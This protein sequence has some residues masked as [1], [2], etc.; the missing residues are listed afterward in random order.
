MRTRKQSTN[1]FHMFDV[2]LDRM[3]YLG[4]GNQLF[5]D[6]GKENHKE[7]TMAVGQHRQ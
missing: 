2:L 4:I 7:E 3:S 6:C 5:G 1:D